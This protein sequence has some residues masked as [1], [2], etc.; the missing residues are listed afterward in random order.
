MMALKIIFFIILY[1]L[2]GVGALEIMLWHDRHSDDFDAWVDDETMQ[3]FIVVFM[4][5]LW[6]WIIL[7]LTFRGLK[8]FIKAVRSFFVA[9]VYMIIALTKGRK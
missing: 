3:V 6:V 2:L 8:K 4:P 9:L 5:F 7:W 1:L